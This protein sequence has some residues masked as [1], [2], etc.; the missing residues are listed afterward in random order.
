V[1]SVPH[2][3][4]LPAAA[5]ILEKL[6]ITNDEAKAAPVAP[7]ARPKRLSASRRPRVA[8]PDPSTL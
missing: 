3:I 6:S 4:G 8:P 7:V 2:T 5:A 1:P